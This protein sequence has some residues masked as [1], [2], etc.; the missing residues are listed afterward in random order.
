MLQWS[1]TDFFKLLQTNTPLRSDEGLTLETSAIVTLTA[2]QCLYQPFVDTQRYH[3]ADAVNLVH[4][5][6]T[7]GIWRV[8][9]VKIKLAGMTLSF[10]NVIFNIREFNFTITKYVSTLSCSSRHYD[11]RLRHYDVRLYNMMLVLTLWCS[12]RHYDVRLNIMMFAPYR[13]QLS[14]EL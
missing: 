7:T 10:H 6:A 14:W 3:H 11:V 12:S 1:K 9:G 13:Q 2:F 8:I 4:C 5:Y